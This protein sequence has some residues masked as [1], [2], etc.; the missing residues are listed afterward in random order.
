MLDTSLTKRSD[1]NDWY[2]ETQQEYKRGIRKMLNENNILSFKLIGVQ[3]I[4]EIS[5]NKVYNLCKTIRKKGIHNIVLKVSF[6][7]KSTYGNFV[8]CQNIAILENVACYVMLDD[9]FYFYNCE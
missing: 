8:R 2:Y 3:V 1:F 6:N 7:K 9:D 4:D 5:L